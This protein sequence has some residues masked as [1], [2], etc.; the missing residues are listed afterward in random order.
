MSFFFSLKQKAYSTLIL[1]LSS[2]EPRHSLKL[3]DNKIGSFT[4]S[5]REVSEE[6]KKKQ[7]ISWTQPKSQYSC[8]LFWTS[9]SSSTNY[10][11][12]NVHL[13]FYFE[14]WWRHKK[15]VF[16]T[17]SLSLKTLNWS[18]SCKLRQ[19][20]ILHF[21][22]SQF[23]LSCWLDWEDCWVDCGCCCCCWSSHGLSMW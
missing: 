22:S 10:E 9:S 8:S 20:N 5:R 12:R 11:F 15:Y 16:T 3:F 19:F 6:V 1:F 17:H 21:F 13:F 18:C 4:S 7:Q 23:A 14:S 2:S